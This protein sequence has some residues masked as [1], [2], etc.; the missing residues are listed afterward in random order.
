MV[1]VILK[2][3]L[4][5]SLVI[6]QAFTQSMFAVDHHLPDEL[7]FTVRI[8][9]GVSRRARFKGPFSVTRNTTLLKKKK[10][11]KKSYRKTKTKVHFRWDQKQKLTVVRSCSQSAR[12]SVFVTYNSTENSPLQSMA[13]TKL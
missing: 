7:L 3:Y 6:S 5:G 11:K 9:N 8:Q 1:H 4:L 2:A 13:G 10:R 12:F